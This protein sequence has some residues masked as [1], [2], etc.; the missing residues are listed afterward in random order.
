MFTETIAKE[1]RMPGCVLQGQMQDK[2][3]PICPECASELFPITRRNNRLMAIMGLGSFLLIG[4]GGVLG[5]GMV[6]QKLSIVET[7]KWLIGRISINDDLGKTPD[8]LLSG[9]LISESAHGDPDKFLICENRDSVNYCRKR[10]P[11]ESGNLFYFD[12]QPKV[13]NLYVFYRGPGNSVPLLPSAG[14]AAKANERIELPKGQRVRISPGADTESFVIVATKA[15]ASALA[16]L[17]AKANPTAAE[18]D[19]AAKPLSKQPDTVV[20]YVDVPHS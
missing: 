13:D 5:F 3:L 14:N 10:V 16:E 8:S 19:Q 2:G 4:S 17:A 15:P 1:C 11:L 7:A 18:I 20:F 6:V 12:L 9:A